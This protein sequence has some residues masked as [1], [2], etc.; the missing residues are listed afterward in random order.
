MASGMVRFLQIEGDSPK[1]LELA[2]HAAPHGR[3]R[4]E[5]VAETD[6]RT[7]MSTVRLP[8]TDIPV[9]HIFGGMHEPIKM[10]G[11]FRDAL[12]GLGFAKAKHDEVEAFVNDRRLCEVIWDDLLDV[13]GIITSYR[14]GIESAGEF[15]Y[16]IEIEVDRDLLA[17]HE[18]KVPESKSPADLTNAIIA[19]LK[20]KDDLPKKPQALRGSI[21]DAL[22]G[23]VGIVNSA[24]AALVHASNDIDSFVTANVTQL[25][26]LR[27]GLAQTRVA[28]QNLRGTYDS[29]V[30]TVALETESADQSQP[31]WDLQSAFQA[32][33]LEALRLI[34]EASR[35]AAIAEQGTILA[36]HTAAV[37]ETWESISAR[38]FEGS[39]SRAGAIREANF[40]PV[41]ADPVPGTTYLVPR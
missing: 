19:A 35:Q 5:A 13:H 24:T 39:S 14:R 15:P 29:L 18:S 8:G 12:G 28:V 9:R 16:E 6:N 7:R 17:G 22:G 36:F 32:S 38:W 27:A 33:S 25:Q 1:T 41:G 10:K 26:R 34:A 37:A 40:V 21:A 30:I 3:P 31:F 2:G 20:L 4:K 11:R 23:L